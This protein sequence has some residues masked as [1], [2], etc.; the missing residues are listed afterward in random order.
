VASD[1]REIASS[2][3]RVASEEVVARTM[4]FDFLGTFLMHVISVCSTTFEKRG[5]MRTYSRSRS[6]S[7]STIS[8]SGDLYAS[9][10]TRAITAA[11]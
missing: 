6:T 1:D 4:S 2:D 9:S 5:P 8:E 10:K 3:S 11:F 7:S